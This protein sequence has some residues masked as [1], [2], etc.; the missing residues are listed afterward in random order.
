MLV[1]RQPMQV[2]GAGQGKALLADN[3]FIGKLLGVGLHVLLIVA[4]CLIHVPTLWASHAEAPVVMLLV[5]LVDLFC[6]EGALAAVAAERLG[7]VDAAHVFG[8]LKAKGEAF[9]ALAACVGVLSSMCHF[10]LSEAL[11]AV[12]GERALA[13]LQLLH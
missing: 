3:T 8:Q 13:T 11:G 9:A 6:S 2:E 5:N 12:S 1:V 4:L 10:M 7:I